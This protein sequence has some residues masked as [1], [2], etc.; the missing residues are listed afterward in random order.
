[1]NTDYQDIKSYKKPNICGNL[2]P[3]LGK[4]ATKIVLNNLTIDLLK[5]LSVKFYF[6]AFCACGP[7]LIKSNQNCL[8]FCF[9]CFIKYPDHIFR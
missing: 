3:N 1:M 2:C 8:C 4:K 5:L 9:K 6:C 7:I